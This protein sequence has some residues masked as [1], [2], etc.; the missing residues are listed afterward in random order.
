MESTFSSALVNRLLQAGSPHTNHDWT[1]ETG[2]LVDVCRVTP[3]DVPALM[4][5]VRG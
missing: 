4:E 5:I 1:L 2:D 3:D